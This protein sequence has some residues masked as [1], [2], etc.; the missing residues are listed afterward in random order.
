MKILKRLT[1]ISAGLV[2]FAASSLAMAGSV[3]SVSNTGQ[4]NCTTGGNDAPHGLWT[5][6]YRPG[7]GGCRQYFGFQEGS[8]LNVNGST[9]QLTATAVNPAGVTAHIDFSFEQPTSKADWEAAGGVI[10]TGGGNDTD[11]WSFYQ[12]GEG[13][14]KV[15]YD[16]EWRG[17]TYRITDRF[18]LDLV[19]RTSFQFG[20]GANDKTGAFGAS[21]WMDIESWTH[22]VMTQQFDRARQAWISIEMPSWSFNHKLGG[23]WDLNMDLNAVPLPAAAW[24]FITGLL[25]VFGFGKYSK[26]RA[27][28]A[29]A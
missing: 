1:T 3:Y 23:H 19:D 10:K 18:T 15:S 5:N 2:L 20:L 25:G 4:V 22:T 27:A 21:A 11:D 8:T 24:L 16:R 6:K 14:I 26:R 12:L 7:T 17:N 29:T 9:A 13:N 28:A